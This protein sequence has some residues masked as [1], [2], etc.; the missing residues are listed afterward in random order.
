MQ[1]ILMFILFEVLLHSRIIRF[2]AVGNICEVNYTM[3]IQ[4]D[5]KIYLPLLEI[6]T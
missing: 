5:V 6:I 3:L 4:I 1:Y 2:K